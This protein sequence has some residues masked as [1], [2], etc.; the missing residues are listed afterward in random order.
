MR[1]MQEH[2]VSIIAA[3]VRGHDSVAI[4]QYIRINGS[5]FLYQQVELDSFHPNWP[6]A[7]GGTLSARQSSIDPMR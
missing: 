2:T 3:S 7:K 6:N 1:R 5:G 4:T